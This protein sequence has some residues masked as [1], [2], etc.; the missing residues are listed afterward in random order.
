MSG[1]IL[2]KQQEKEG[3]IRTTFKLGEISS[4]DPHQV[5]NLEAMEEGTVA[6]TPNETTEGNQVQIE[7][8]S[9]R[10]HNMESDPN[11]Q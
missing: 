2:P 11:P 5:T 4:R 10:E 6:K 8:T 1:K 7:H 9:L 3:Y